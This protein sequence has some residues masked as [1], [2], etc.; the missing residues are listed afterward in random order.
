[1]PMVVLMESHFRPIKAESMRTTTI[2][3]MRKKKIITSQETLSTGTN[4]F[5]YNGEMNNRLTESESHYVN[6]PE[7]SDDLFAG[8]VIQYDSHYADDSQAIYLGNQWLWQLDAGNK[9]DDYN[10]HVMED[11]E[12]ASAD[13]WDEMRLVESI[14]G[15]WPSLLKLDL[16]DRTDPVVA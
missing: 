2:G 13:S 15:H 7:K 10:Y 9:D 16:E 11:S 14:F 3:Q 4:F 1:M 12:A 6:G 8:E 5:P